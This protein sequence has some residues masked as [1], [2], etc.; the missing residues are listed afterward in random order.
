LPSPLEF[1]QAVYSNE[2]LPLSAR[3]KAAV[4]AAQYVHPKLAVTATINSGD[5]ATQL[6]QAV[7]RSRKVSPTMIEGTVTATANVS[8]DTPRPVTNGGGKPPTIIDRRYRRW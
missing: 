7:E 8:S 4:E 3:L 6:D 2:G 1:L 5:F